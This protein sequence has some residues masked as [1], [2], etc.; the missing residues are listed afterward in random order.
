MLR[1]KRIVFLSTFGHC[2]ID[3]MH[4][5]L[6]SHKQ[7][8]IPPALSFFRCWKMLK[9]DSAKN[10]DEMF[11]IWH[12]YITKYI[13]H[14]SKNEQKKILHSRQEEELF[15]S[16][17][18]N[19]LKRCS[20]DR[21]DTFWAINESYLYAKGINTDSINIVVAHEHL[22]WPFEEILTEFENV[23]FLMMVRDPRAAIAG[24]IK[25]RVDDFGFLPDFTFNTIIET[26][27]Q[28]NDIYSKYNIKFG[29]SLKIVKNEDLH[30]SLESNMIDVANWLGVDFNNSMLIPT[31]EL[32]VI[33]T[34]DSRYLDESNQKIDEDVFFSPKS[35]KER[36][37]N[38]LKDPHDILMIEIL[39]KEL[40]DEF[41]YKRIYKPSYFNHLKGIIFFLLPSHFIVIKW[42]DDYPDLEDFSRIDNRLKKRLGF[43]HSIWKILP[44][45]IKF[46]F[47][48][49]FSIMRRIK[50]YFAPGK[51][52][53]R[54][55][56]D[57]ANY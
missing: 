32:G 18:H 13:G 47:L 8:L 56:N 24:I 42:L 35:V 15:F 33:H 23:N 25:G 46:S 6:H 17:L 28:G 3:W 20:L 40:M 57:I 16:E 19:Q 49:A 36:W 52:W 45:P 12:S 54:Y 27:L 2:G 34:P 30:E 55:D 4:S 21:V 48:Y 7:I 10:S 11:E 53:K 1:N 51:R 22:P 50:I 9:A 26:W 14:K 38:V 44:S 37:L 41:G 43:T 31:N 29:H 39:F 5:L